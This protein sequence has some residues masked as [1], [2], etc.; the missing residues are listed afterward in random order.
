MREYPQVA[1]SKEL[2]ASKDKTEVVRLRSLLFGKK[3][4][5]TPHSYSLLRISQPI[6]DDLDRFLGGVPYDAIGRVLL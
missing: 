3:L 1:S 4:L 2:V 5:P 6:V